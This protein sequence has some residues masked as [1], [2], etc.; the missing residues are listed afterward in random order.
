MSGG[1][2]SH[3]GV[4][5]E[6]Q[7][8]GAVRITQRTH[9]GQVVREHVI[10]ADTWASIVAAVSLKGTD[11]AQRERALLLHNSAQP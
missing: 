2:H 6:R 11:S 8:D 4:H 9:G 5:W 3:S 1:Y 7:W 10:D